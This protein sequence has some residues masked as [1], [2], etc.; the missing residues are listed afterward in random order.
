MTALLNARHMSDDE[1]GKSISTFSHNTNG[2]LFLAEKKAG[3][4]DDHT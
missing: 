1:E 2:I 3:G 4:E